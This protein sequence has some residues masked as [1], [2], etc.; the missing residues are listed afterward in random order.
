MS[1][2]DFI[3]PEQRMADYVRQ[4]D[5]VAQ[6][7]SAR[8]PVNA[9][10][11]L[12]QAKARQAS[13]K[14]ED[15]EQRLGNYCAERDQ[16]AAKASPLHQADVNN[17][18]AKVR[19]QSKV[20]DTA[21]LVSKSGR[22]NWNR[23]FLRFATATA[24]IAVCGIA[25]VG[26]FGRQIKQAFT[27]STAAMA[28]TSVKNSNEAKT[29]QVKTDTIGT[30]DKPSNS[31]EQTLIDYSDAANQA[32]AAY[33]QSNYVSAVTLADKA[34]SIRKADATMQ[35][36]K[37]EILRQLDCSLANLLESFNVSVPAEIKYA[38]LKKAST[39]GSVGKIG[40]P[41]YQAQVDK[42]EKAYRAGNWLGE[43]NRQSSLDEL[44][45]AIEGWE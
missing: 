34:L 36:L 37:T 10:A 8:H 13:Q 32:Q 35:K 23:F 20:A 11:I 31:A 5:L 33:A 19:Q 28:G 18:L 16:V 9:A 6:N 24:L 26:E 41:Y 25:I 4:R 3:E 39:L 7:A 27:S 40:K 29:S 22:W 30:F 17:L 43:A 44:R 45:K 42:L 1:N 12:Q 15:V 38:E 2:F 21:D 14:Q